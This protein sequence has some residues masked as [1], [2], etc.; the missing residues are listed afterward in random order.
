[1]HVVEELH[2]SIQE[3]YDLRFMG[4]RVTNAVC[5]TLFCAREVVEPVEC[6]FF[7]FRVCRGLL[8]AETAVSFVAVWVC[9]P[10]VVC[11]LQ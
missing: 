4:A 7:F 5:D 8:T 11:R 9:F 6:V 1:M 10:V 2:N 3:E